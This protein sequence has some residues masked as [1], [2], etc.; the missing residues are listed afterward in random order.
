LLCS[1]QQRQKRLKTPWTAVL[2]DFTYTADQLCNLSIMAL[3]VV[4]QF[5]KP[6]SC[7]ILS[8]CKYAISAF[9]GGENQD[10]DHPGYDAV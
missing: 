8:A 1:F 4:S 10:C 6:F 7:K 9:H 5:R 2:F 3:K